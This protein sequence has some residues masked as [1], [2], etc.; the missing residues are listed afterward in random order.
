M[1]TGVLR[2]VLVSKPPLG[3]ETDKPHASE[4]TGNYQKDWQNSRKMLDTVSEADAVY[5]FDL[6]IF[7]SVRIQKDPCRKIGPVAV[8]RFDNLLVYSGML[9][10]SAHYLYRSSSLDQDIKAWRGHLP[11]GLG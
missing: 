9:E 11:M 8:Q 4:G 3:L 5:L 2:R 6:W 1:Q 7:I 10:P